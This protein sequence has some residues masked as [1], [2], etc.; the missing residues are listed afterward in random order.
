MPEIHGFELV[1]DEEIKE[2]KSI[3]RVYRHVKTGAELISVIND[4]E[5]KAFCITF[6]TPPEDSTGVAHILEHAVLCGSRKYPLKEPFVELIKGSLNT[7]LN[8][9]TGDS[10][11]YYPVASLNTQDFYN[12]VD[13]YLDA[14]FYP[15]IPRE[16]FEQEGWHHELDDKDS[17]IVYR[18]V[19]FNE[20]KGAYASPDTVLYDQSSRALFPDHVYGVS[21]GGEPKHIPDLTYEYFKNFHQ[22]FYH[23]SNAMIWFWG[24]D[25]PEER[26]RILNEYLKDF[27]PRKI[28]ATVPLAPHFTEPKR[29][30]HNY[31]IGSE[32]AGEKGM[33]AI[34]WVIS[35]ALDPEFDMAADILRHILAGTPAAPLR[36]ALLD[37]GLVEDA[38][39]GVSDIR[40]RSFRV[41]MKG[42]DPA[43]T[44]KVEE[45]VFSTLK[46]LA[47]EG[48][49]SDAI[50]ASL[51]TAEFNMRELN[52]GGFPRGLAVLF[53]SMSH[54]LYDADPI[55]PLKF[56]EPL[57]AVK[58]GIAKGRYFEKIIQTALL[59]N[60]H[61]VT[62][63]FVPDPMLAQK[64]ADA[65]LER[66]K[67]FQ[68]SL[69]EPELEAIV[70]DT[71]RLQ[72][73]QSTPDSEEALATLPRLKLSDLDPNAKRTPNIASGLIGC[74]TYY[75]DLFTNGIV[76]ADIGFDLRGVSQEL[77]PYL[78]L[79]SR[80]LLQLG[81]ETEDFVTLTQRIGR[82]T[83]GIRADLLV[84]SQRG[85][86]DAIAKLML[87]TKSTPSQ[88]TDL[89]AILQDIILTARLD[90]K[91]RFRQMV[92]EEK[93]RL[94]AALVPSGS[95]FVARRLGSRFTE[96]GWIGEQLGGVSYLF[97]IRELIN[98]VDTDWP[99]VLATLETLRSQILTA[100]R[101]ICNVT[102]DAANFAVLQPKLAELIATLPQGTTDQHAW[103]PSWESRPEGLTIPGQ[104]NHV[105][106][107]GRL[108]D[109]GYQPHGSALVISNYI[110][111]SWLWQKVR[112][113]GGAYGGFCGYD[114]L[115]SVFSFGSYRDPNLMA[116]L[117]NFDATANFLREA[118]LSEAELTRTVI[119]TIGDL[120]S[121]QLPD[122]KG[123]SQFVRELVG[124][125]DEL[126]QRRRDEVLGTTV[127]DFRQFAEVLSNVAVNGDVVVVGSSEKIDEA[128]TL[129]PDWLKVT[130]V[131]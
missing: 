43:D 23:P 71:K 96:S 21:S 87:R 75:H 1:R 85:S 118:N 8:A 68:A 122:A 16:A 40:Q 3:A 80:S 9:F 30:T 123:Y 66:L 31:A 32:E 34:G 94:E 106:K 91:E 35:D 111:T 27:E 121:Y 29:L 112:M 115:S 88:T 110:R 51:N 117:Q 89:L 44:D 99:G 77:L 126:R 113:E 82:K 7:F 100:G 18:G 12:L 86:T 24:D 72:E 60:P 13:V 120:D 105:G 84:T 26:L 78:S 63:S 53:S 124:E 6:R 107:A 37:S 73:S 2:L 95:S 20:M 52:T 109:Y 10:E 54:W 46:K 101:A 103:H 76:Y 45:L 102:L 5:N 14:V 59:D 38:G 79:F 41:S 81:T 98:Q 108:L 127:N 55:A 19:V 42:I 11:T 65:E 48:I 22:T 104:V 62:I 119:G 92:L 116:T 17:A 33:M 83:G 130:K 90:N 58:A 39:A 125:T 56:E 70:E 93:V 97:F 129:K 67:T 128:N 50:E 64:E 61:R 4:D 114:I 28:E 15:R 36:K 49:P 74:P 57:A 25:N 131:L 69:G 47:E